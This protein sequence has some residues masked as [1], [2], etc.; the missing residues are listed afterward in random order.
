[1]K[2]GMQRNGLRRFRCAQCGK[3]YTEGRTG[4]FGSM[5]VPEDKSA[6]GNPAFA[7]RQYFA[8]YNF[9]SVHHTLR[10]SPAMESGISD[11]IWTLRELLSE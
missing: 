1:M 2:F 9:C 6:A 4:L 11:H 3:T 10:V 8:Y 5:T 7:G